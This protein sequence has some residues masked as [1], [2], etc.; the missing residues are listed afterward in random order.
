M[1]L[2]DVDRNMY[3]EKCT[4]PLGLYKLHRNEEVHGEK[5]ETNIFKNDI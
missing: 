2:A 4:I 3:D 1:F 5:T